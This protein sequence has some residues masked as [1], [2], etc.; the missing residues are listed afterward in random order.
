[1]N[2]K[3]EKKGGISSIQIRISYPKTAGAP[4]DPDPCVT[5]MK[6]MEQMQVLPQ[7]YNV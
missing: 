3:G 5:S 7:A 6:S 2:V 1:V 4:I